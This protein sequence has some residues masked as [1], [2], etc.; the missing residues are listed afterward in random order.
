MKNLTK[1]ILAFA[2]SFAMV[3]TMVPFTAVG[4][5]ETNDAE[6]V[7]SEEIMM[8]NDLYEDGSLDDFYVDE[9]DSGSVTIENVEIELD[10]II[11][12]TCGYYDYYYDEDND[13]EVEYYRYDPWNFR[14]TFTYTLTNGEEYTSSSC[15]LGTEEYD[16]YLDYDTKQGQEEQWEAGG[17]YEVT[18]YYGDKEFKTTVKIAECPIESMTFETRDVMCGTGGYMS[19][20]WKD[21]VEDYV[22]YYCYSASSFFDGWT[23]YL[24]NGDVIEGEDTCFFYDGIEYYFEFDSAQ[25][26]NNPWGEGVHELTARVMGYETTFDVN[27]IGCPIESMTAKTKEV[28]YMTRGEYEWGYDG[29]TDEEIKYFRYY[30]HAFID[31]W[32]IVMTDGEVINV[33]GDE[34]TYNGKDYYIDYSSDQGPRNEWGKG[35]HQMTASVM[36]YETTFDVVV[37]DSAVESIQVETVDVIENTGGYYGWGENEDGEEVKFYEYDGDSFISKFIITMKNGDVIETSGSWFE[38]DDSE[39]NVRMTDNQSAANP[40]G[41]GTHQLTANVMGE[42]ITFDVNIIE[43]PV[44]DVTVETKDVVEGTCGY[45][46]YDWDEDSETEIAYYKYYPGEFVETVTVTMKNGEEIVVNYDEEYV[47]ED[48]DVYIEY[49]DKWYQIEVDSNQSAS[50]PWGLGEHEIA[51]SVLGGETTVP[52]TITGS[53][54]ESIEFSTSDIEAYS[55]GYYNTGWED[56]EYSAVWFK[57]TDFY[58]SYVVT[59]ENG[60]TVKSTKNYFT[61]NGSEYELTF[62]TDQSSDNQ[63]DVG[64]HS[65]M[66]SVAGIET[67]FDVNIVEPPYKSVE[68]ISVEE[69]EADRWGDY[70]YPEIAL[71][72]TK[73]DGSTFMEYINSKDEWGESSRPDYVYVKWDNLEGPGGENCLYLCYAG[74]ELYVPVTIVESSDFSYVEHEEGLFVTGYTGYEDTL[75]IPESINGKTVVGLAFNGYVD[76]LIVPDSV[77]YVSDFEDDYS[78]RKI[79]LGAGVGNI[80]SDTFKRCRDLKQIV[81][82]EDNPYYT[83]IDGVVYDKDVTTLIAFPPAKTGEYYVP[84]T[85]TN[86]D[87]L[88]DYVTENLTVIFASEDGQ[89]V[90]VDGVTYNADMTEVVYC[91]KDKAGEYIMP[92]SVTKI[93]SGAF[94]NCTKLTD[95]TV[96]NKVTAITYEDFANCTSLANVSMPETVKSIDAGAFRKCKNLTSI[97]IPAQTTEIDYMAFTYSGIK[98]AG[99]LDSVKTIGGR[100]F[101]NTPLESIVF[102]EALSFIGKQAFEKTSLKSVTLPESLTDIEDFAFNDSLLTSITIPDSVTYLGNNAFANNPDMASAVI[103]AGVNYI[104]EC[105]FNGCDSLTTVDVRGTNVSVGQGAFV[106]TAL[107]EINTENLGDIGSYAFVGTNIRDLNLTDGVT[108]VEYKAFENC[109]NLTDIEMPE[110]IEVVAGHAFDK[111]AWYNSQE[112]GATYLGSVLY[113]IKGKLAFDTD[114]LIKAGTTVLADIAFEHEEGLKSITLPEGLTRIGIG[115]FFGCYNLTEI[116][117]PG[118]VTSVGKY[119]FRNCESLTTIN[120]ADGKGIVYSENNVLYGDSGKELIYAARRAD[121]TLTVPPTVRTIRAGAIENSGI[122]TLIIKGKNTTIENNDEV[123]FYTDLEEFNEYDGV[124]IHCIEGSMA[125]EFAKA[126]CLRVV[127]IKDETTCKKHS[128]GEWIERDSATCTADGTEVR[129]CTVC[130][131]TESKIIPA[132]G[133]SKAGYVS[134]NVVEPELQADGSYKPGSQDKVYNCINCGEELSRETVKIVRESIKVEI[135]EINAPVRVDVKSE[136]T[137]VPDTI[138][139]SVQEVREQLKEAALNEGELSRPEEKIDVVFMDVELKVQDDNGAWDNVEDVDFPEEGVTIILPYPEGI[140]SPEAY[141]FVVAHMI[142][143]DNRADGLK[144]GDIE[145][146]TPIKTTEGLKVTVKSLSPFAIAYHEHIGGAAATCTTAQTCTVCGEVIVKALDH[147]YK[148]VVT[149]PTCKAGGYT[150][151]TCACGDSYVADKV[152]AKGHT[153][154]AAATCTTAQKCTVCD[155]ELA[156]ATGHSYKAAVTAPTCTEEGYTTYTCECGDSY[157]ADKVAAKG[158]SYGAYVTTKK[159][160]FGKTGV[161]TA[162]CAGCQETQTK[163]IAAAKIPTLSVTAYTY[164]GKVKKPAVTVKNSDGA[165]LAKSV[166]YAKGRKNVGTYKVTVKLTGADYTGSKVVTFKINPKGT[167]ISKLTKPAKKQIKVTWKKQKTQVTGYEIQYSTSKKFTKKTTKTVKVNSYKTTSKTIKKLKAKQKYYVQIRTYKTVNGTKYYSGWSAKKSIKTK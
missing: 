26:A 21:E 98:D 120:V 91:D 42:T 77:K 71:K 97:D 133:H 81:V 130:G 111:T 35:T 152:A 2:I 110:S 13:E 122:H 116:N 55:H 117:L 119:A 60:D 82:S 66:A 68:I 63:W 75:E 100:A 28:P 127:Y 118:T 76:E 149:A 136:V 164:N 131:E 104:P 69:L 147:S 30:E 96:S 48:N 10:E 17:E 88:N 34:F 58:E 73:T 121:G 161:Q 157:V 37:G 114:L 135:P 103:G 8:A 57:Y 143:S 41:V 165:S 6:P 74:I 101:S 78:M 7:Q 94:R 140:S 53:P 128:Y 67:Y 109:T 108:S 32:T 148:A 160:T 163:T 36:G 154:G 5:A 9:G 90:T 56:E 44:A 70:N 11:A 15:Y 20:D 151:Y 125:D 18:Y 43:S 134:E 79:T 137:T 23:I 40:W 22:E 39:F 31:G 29:D 106:N 139:E 83:S 25:S 159:A 59:M 1:K 45:L 19:E 126:N 153:P 144:A 87:V 146:L 16:L 65:V 64:E 3:A 155:A 113:D 145:Y 62:D 150:T 129:E 86:L 162:T 115:T 52:V 123:D 124:I 95:V 166:T 138:N 92:E 167:S 158:H 38:Y 80:T 49:N 61:Y 12:F 102:T 4:Y 46:S 112:N 93:A 85:V 47:P 84:A 89:F 54:I 72:V 105:A 27:I 33:E 107:S 132:T 24:K 14:G 141:E 156:K 99:T 50:D 51:V 142:T